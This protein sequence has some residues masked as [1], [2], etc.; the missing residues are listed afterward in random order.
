MSTSKKDRKFME[1]AVEEMLQSRSEH[2]HKYDP[3]VGAV[4]VGPDGHVLGKAHRGSL[5]DG[6]HAEFTLI[7]RLLG[8][9]N[10]EGSTLYITLEPCTERR[11]PKV[12]CARRVVSA[13]IRR[14]FIGMLDPNP[15]I[16]GD[17]LGYLQ[18]NQVEVDFFDLDLIQQIR[19]D[20]KDFIEQYD[21]AEETLS[22]KEQIEGPSDKEKELVPT[23]S[24]DDFDRVLVKDYL[25]ARKIELPIP[26]TEL[27]EFFRKNNFVGRDGNRNLYVPT[28]AGFLLFAKQPEDILVQSK[29][30]VEAQ[31]GDKLIAPDLGGPLLLLPERIKDFLSQNMQRYV[32]IKEFKRTEEPEYPWDA[33][34]EAVVNAIVHRDYR[35]GMRVSIQLLRDRLVVKSPGP[36]LR[37]L[38]LAK[39]REYNAPPYSRNPRIADTFHHLSLMEERGWGLE[40]MR[41]NLVSR[42]LPLPRFNM[43]S[44]YFVVTFFGPEGGPGKVQ[45]STDLSARLSERHKKIVDLVRHKGK[46]SR[47]DVVAALKVSPNTAK[48][49]L[50]GLVELGLLEQRGQGA[51]THYVLWGS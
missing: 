7:E 17:G 51:S 46:V 15:D 32:V 35:E 48:R 13:R 40:K 14:A 19:E 49:D 9:Q 43:D 11:P 26:S 1:M 12:S 47:A 30:K 42:D 29:V 50:G 45:I 6:D 33:V 3:M 10:L 22:E 37:P 34:R 18:Q 24:I 20:N 44:G 2:T 27:W 38:S 36:P 8:D 16:Q 23:A 4:L 31:K 28:V 21:L 5:R 39:I 41:K 25:I